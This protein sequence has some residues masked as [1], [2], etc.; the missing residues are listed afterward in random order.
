MAE[1]SEIEKAFED[2]KGLRDVMFLLKAMNANLMLCSKAVEDFDDLS[3]AGK[4]LFGGSILNLGAMY[5]ASLTTIGVLATKLQD[6][7]DTIQSEEEIEPTE[8]VLE[9]ITKDWKK[10]TLN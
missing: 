6:K 8:E 10:L 3:D 2:N 5:I 1:K 7:P 9:K 4:Q